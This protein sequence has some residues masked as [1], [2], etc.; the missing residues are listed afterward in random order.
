MADCNLLLKIDCPEVY[1]YL[2]QGLT[3]FNSIE[4][5]LDYLNSRQSFI[6]GYSGNNTW[7]FIGDCWLNGEYKVLSLKNLVR[8]FKD[9]HF[10]EL[11][12]NIEFSKWFLIYNA[13]RLFQQH[14]ND[15]EFKR[16]LNSDRRVEI[17]EDELKNLKDEK[18]EAR[19]YMRINQI[20]PKHDYNG[21]HKTFT[22]L[23][24]IKLI[25]N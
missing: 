6:M 21:N 23:I 22:F 25:K 1:A 9:E 12:K 14:I 15:P 19:E 17:I 7:L 16:R 24:Q 2:N 8:K 13:E 4:E 10:A 11:N 18:D 3:S 5:K 20:R